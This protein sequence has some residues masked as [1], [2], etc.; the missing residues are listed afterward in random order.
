MEEKLNLDLLFNHS[1]TKEDDYFPPCTILINPDRFQLG[2]FLDDGCGGVVVTQNK[3]FIFFDNPECCDN[4]HQYDDICLA[5]YTIYNYCIK[6]VFEEK[7]HIVSK[8]GVCNHRKAMDLISKNYWNI[9]KTPDN[10]NEWLD[11]CSSRLSIDNDICLIYEEWEEQRR[12]C[13]LI[14][15]L[16][17]DPQPLDKIADFINK[18]W[19]KIKTTDSYTPISM[20]ALYKD[21]RIIYLHI[22]NSEGK[23]DFRWITNGITQDLGLF[24]S[25][26]DN[27]ERFKKGMER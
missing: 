26:L 11:W 7:I 18:N 17:S 3:H 20:Y 16:E 1:N 13:D 19:P 22:N 25:N 4:Y 12:D 9:L 23:V 27:G 24:T 21:N 5:R 8:E 15:M 10:F 2:E 14:R 6:G